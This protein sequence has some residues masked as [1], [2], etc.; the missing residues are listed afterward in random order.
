VLFF[1]GGVRAG[2]NGK[3]SEETKRAESCQK[4]DGKGAENEGVALH[5]ERGGLEKKIRVEPESHGQ[6]KSCQNI[7][8]CPS[9]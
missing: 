3:K 1:L 9:G 4:K 7:R 8:F 5:S 6:K 2:K